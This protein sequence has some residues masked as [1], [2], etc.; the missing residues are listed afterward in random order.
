MITREMRDSD[1]HALAAINTALSRFRSM[2]FLVSGS[3]AIEA[4]T[5]N[6]VD[7]VDM[8]ANVFTADLLGAMSTTETVLNSFEIARGSLQLYKKTGDRLEYDV[9]MTEQ[10]TQR[11]LE[12]HFVEAT[13]SSSTHP[14]VFI[15][16]DANPQISRV[17]LVEASLK[18]SVGK[19][20]PFKVKSLAYSLA[21]WALRI[22]GVA[23]NQLRPVR[24]SDLECF[25]VLLTGVFSSEEIYSAI[26]HHPQAPKNSNPVEVFQVAKNILTTNTDLVP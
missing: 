4:L 9:R 1:I 25:G 2:S 26:E 19:V 11:R 16:R 24:Q 20:F 7:H 5:Q 14:Q 15:L 17:S 22:S 21:T 13:P 8:D 18:D 12:F 10:P 6:P 3:Y 23:Q